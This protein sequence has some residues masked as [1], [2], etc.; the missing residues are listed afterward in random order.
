[1]LQKNISRTEIIPERC[2]VTGVV[3]FSSN[4]GL[5]VGE[6]HSQDTG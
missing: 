4:L 1:M 6:L 5:S 2:T 3:A